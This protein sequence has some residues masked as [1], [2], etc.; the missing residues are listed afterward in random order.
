VKVS[1]N[2]IWFGDFCVCCE[3]PKN[4]LVSLENE[5]EAMLLDIER[6]EQYIAGIA[7]HNSEKEANMCAISEELKQ[8]GVCRC[9]LH[10]LVYYMLQWFFAAYILLT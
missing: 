1:Q 9:Q 10:K 7:K 2:A 3:C 5:N 8:K 4:E 6:L